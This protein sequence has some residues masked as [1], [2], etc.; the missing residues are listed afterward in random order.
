M[1]SLLYRA[2]LASFTG[3]GMQMSAAQ[4]LAES[5]SA[6]MAFGLDRWGDQERL[7][8]LS[9]RLGQLQEVPLSPSPGQVHMKLA[10][11][12]CFLLPLHG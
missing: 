6:A 8:A 5:A 11:H 7:E 1:L 2:A 9:K 10:G 3:L 12:H 4:Q